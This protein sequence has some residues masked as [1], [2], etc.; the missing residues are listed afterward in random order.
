MTVCG[1]CTLG[2]C[3]TLLEHSSQSETSPAAGR[4][5]LCCNYSDEM[6][7]LREP[8]SSLKPWHNLL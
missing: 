2:Q 3:R 6:N 4:I 7:G 1:F 5:C 8:R